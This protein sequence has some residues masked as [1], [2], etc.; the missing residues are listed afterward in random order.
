MVIYDEKVEREV[1]QS[2]NSAYF[3]GTIYPSKIKNTVAIVVATAFFVLLFLTTIFFAYAENVYIQVYVEGKSMHPTLNISYNSSLDDKK[4]DIVYLNSLD[5]GSNG[6]IIVDHYYVSSKIEYVI[7]RLIAV[8][9]DTLRIYVP[10]DENEPSKIYVNGKLLVENYISQPHFEG[11]KFL[12]DDEEYNKMHYPQFNPIGNSKDGTI[13]IPK[14]YVFYMGDNRATNAS[15]DCR[16]TGPRSSEHII[17]KVD[18]IV[19]YGI[20]EDISSSTLFWEGAQ[21]V[22][23]KIF[24]FFMI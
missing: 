2:S 12:T 11:L 17:G 18:F 5:C 1:I 14:G 3:N 16:A 15:Y 9:G 20:D 13:T 22:L 24:S 23:D 19:R 21:R 7:K 8:E 6:D 4:S 10:E